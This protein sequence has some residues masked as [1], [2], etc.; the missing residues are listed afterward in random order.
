M[1]LP[2]DFRASTVTKFG[3]L[4]KRSKM[5]L[6][7]FLGVFV[8][9]QFHAELFSQQDLGGEAH[10]LVDEGAPRSSRVLSPITT[11]QK[12][13]ASFVVDLL[14]IGSRRR[15]ELLTAQ[16]QSFGSHASVRHFF[17]A[18]EDDDDDPHC[19][20]NL[21]PKDAYRISQFCKHQQWDQETHP[22]MRFLKN[23]YASST[24]LRKK[25]NPVGWMC[26][27]RRPLHG[28][29]K[30]FQHYK[31][32]GE[33]LP[34]YLIIMDD[35]TYFNLEQFQYLMQQNPA[36]LQDPSV[37]AGCLVRVPI[38]TLNFT[39]GFGGYGTIFNQA[40]LQRF[41]EPIHCGDS[42]SSNK[43]ACGQLER[44]SIGE[45]K[46]FQ[47]GMSVLELL[48]AYVSHEPYKDRDTWTDGYCMHSDWV[49]GFFVNHYNISSHVQEPYYQN[50]PQARM[51][52]WQGSVIYKEP[53]GFCRN[54]HVDKCQP[55]S[56]TC[57]YMTPQAMTNYTNIVKAK[58]PAGQ[59][60]NE[61]QTSRL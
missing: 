29:Y 40:S 17:N 52:E 21:T 51:E 30:V 24:W 44:N 48:K 16:Q 53:Q 1:K 4:T 10:V 11:Q 58:A 43:E 34:D 60:R 25:K 27:Q 47:N 15:P 18:T 37:L 45:Q 31:R 46:L 9:V 6:F 39:F 5:H 42:V 32:T 22:L 12:Q 54:D 35:D 61:L 7:L 2:T 8:V 36:N 33:S 49:L 13:K 28:L 20:S 26:A 23:C 57:H 59:F 55:D 56:V 41:L 19:D 3:F 38:M 14:S 50:V